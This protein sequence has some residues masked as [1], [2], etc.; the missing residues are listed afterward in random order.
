MPQEISHLDFEVLETSALD[1]RQRA[2]LLELFASNYRDADPGFVDRSLSTL[3][4]VAVAR[5]RGT[6]IGFA[7]GETRTMDLPR[8][9]GQIVNLAG[10]CCIDPAFRRHGLFGDLTR[11]AMGSDPHAGTA[12]R[13][14]CGRVAHPAAYRTIAR[15]AGTVPRAGIPPTPWQRDVGR[16]IAAAYRVF[17]FDPDTFVCI[18]RGCPIGVPRIEFEIEPAEWQAFAAVDRSRGDALLALGWLPDAPP[19]W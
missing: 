16:V 5:D 11:R 10:L 14:F 9:P 4:H 18:G 1:P 19:G 2:A 8:L 12:R 6:A 17:D 15:L 13:L 3:R 7:L